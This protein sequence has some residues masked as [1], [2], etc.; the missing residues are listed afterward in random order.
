MSFAAR[1]I[2]EVTIKRTT[3]DETDPD[4]AYGQP[5]ESTTEIQVRALIQPKKADEMA[6]SRGAGAMIGDHTIY[7]LPM[8]LYG[9]DEIV[10][11]QGQGYRVM[12]I[13]SFEFGRT[14]HVAV[15]ALAIT[16]PNDNFVSVGS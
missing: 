6:D 4:D 12:G 8:L 13:R 1:L 10:D 15:D 3:F 5:S 2:H 14:P 9:S 11:S 7:F 16:P